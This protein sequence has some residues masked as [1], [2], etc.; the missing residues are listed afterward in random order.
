MKAACPEVKI[1]ISESK[2]STSLFSK[3]VDKY[4]GDV[5]DRYVRA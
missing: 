4:V 3:I 1:M 2:D 5:S